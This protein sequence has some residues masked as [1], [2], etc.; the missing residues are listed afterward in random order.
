MARLVPPGS[1]VNM[2]IEDPLDKLT[3]TIDLVTKVGSYFQVASDKKNQNHMEKLESVLNMMNTGSQFLNVETAEKFQNQINVITEE[4]MNS[5]DSTLQM[6]S[7]I[8][9]N[10]A[11][12][13]VNTANNFNAAYMSFGELKNDPIFN[14]K[15]YT[16]IGEDGKST[17]NKKFISEIN[18]MGADKWNNYV[19]QIA[20]L[21]TQ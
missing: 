15:N 7:E 9:N 11:E 21:K 12:G 8:A 13:A 3:K 16:T 19:T 14:I 2:G 17:L 1:A 4:A 5:G 6:A 20:S 10:V 18:N